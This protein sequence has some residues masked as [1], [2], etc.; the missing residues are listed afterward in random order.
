MARGSKRRKREQFENITEGMINGEIIQLCT[1]LT[2][3]TADG[4]KGC[5]TQI[6]KKNQRKRNHHGNVDVFISWLC[7]TS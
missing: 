4:Y 7:C 2:Y 1:T 6:R 3:T 5:I